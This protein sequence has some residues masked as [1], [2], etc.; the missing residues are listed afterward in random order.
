MNLTISI[1]DWNHD[2]HVNYRSPDG[3]SGRFQKGNVFFM[4][5]PCLDGRIRFCLSLHIK[6]NSGDQFEQ[7][8]TL[9]KA[10]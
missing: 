2:E 7:T 9:R 1:G 4:W 3:E 5:S 10:S 8:I 6:L